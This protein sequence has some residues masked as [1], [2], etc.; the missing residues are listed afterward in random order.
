MK[1]IV[2]DDEQDILAI[3]KKFLNRCGF[4][5]LTAASGQQALSILR[6]H[7]KADLL[8][9]DMKMPGISGT[10]VLRELKKHDINI[11]FLMLTGS[12]DFNKHISALENI[13]YNNIEAVIKPVDLNILLDKI[14]NKV[15]K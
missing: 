3:L 15:K 12:I 7:C 2:V 11:P 14:K 4:E 5:V 13:G 10:E 8:V 1:I 9:I 6:Q